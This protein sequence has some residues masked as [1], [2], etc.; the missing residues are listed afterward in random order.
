MG[1]NEMKKRSEMVKFM[2]ILRWL[3]PLRWRSW[4]PAPDSRHNKSK[5]LEIPISAASH[6]VFRNFVLRTGFCRTPFA[7]SRGVFDPSAWI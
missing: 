2:K 1:D 5:I 6:G 4:S 7:A 3:M